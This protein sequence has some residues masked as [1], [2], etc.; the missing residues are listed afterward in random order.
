VHDAKEAAERILAA[1]AVLF[2]W[3][4][5]LADA[6]GLLPGARG[7]LLSIGS[8]GYIL[9][10]NSTDDPQSLARRL[11]DA[12]IW[13]EAERILLAGEQTLL[14][15]AERA[16]GEPV[17]LV[18]SPDMTE[19]ATRLGLRTAPG[20]ADTLVILRDTAFTFARLKTAANVAR[21]CQ[22]IVL[23]NP[24]LTHP[25]PN[26][27]VQPETGAFF[28]AIKACLDG[29]EPSVEV[30]GKPNPHLFR[31]A[32]NHAGIAPDRAVMIGDNPDT[33]G[34]GAAACGIPFIHV[35]PDGPLTMRHLA[36]SVVPRTN[37]L[38]WQGLTRR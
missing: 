13:F 26:G 24:D 36:G 17:H 5:C 34:A 20:E 37:P 30:V 14:L 33:D 38:E 15:E 1:D 32:L 29:H 8:R 27:T 35:H 19:R 3:D 21:H 7:M 22:R 11:N 31:L 16:G 28:A 6:D 25:G 9:S 10:N 2:D 4:G 12:G 18:A 23:S